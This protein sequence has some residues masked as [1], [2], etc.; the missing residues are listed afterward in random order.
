[1]G[2]ASDTTSSTTRVESGTTATDGGPIDLP[3][4]YDAPPY[5]DGAGP[6]SAPPPP[7]PVARPAPPAQD[8]PTNEWTRRV[9]PPS[10]QRALA[11]L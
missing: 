9:P 2:K 11:P 10:A 1:M 6:S 8:V 3:P 5:E 4:S 7:A